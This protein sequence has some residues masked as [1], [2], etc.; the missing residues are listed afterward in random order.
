MLGLSNKAW[1]FLLGGLALGFIMGANLS[2]LPGSAT[3]YGYGANFAQD[4]KLTG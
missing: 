3:V 4:G 2:W 1:M